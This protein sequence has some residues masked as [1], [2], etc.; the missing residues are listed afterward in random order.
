MIA[1]RKHITDKKDWNTPPKYVQII[2]KFFNNNIELDPCSNEY[3]FINAKTK[4]IFP[5]KNGL[6]EIWN[7]KTIFVNPPYG[8]NK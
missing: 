4:F 1:G 8:R 7:Y 5:E 2:N 6:N 3:S